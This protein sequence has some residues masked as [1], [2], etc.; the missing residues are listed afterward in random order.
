MRFYFHII[1][2]LLFSSCTKEK[3]PFES[4]KFD[5]QI[6]SVDSTKRI[7]SIDHLVLHPSG[8][9]NV[10]SPSDS[11]D[12]DSLDLDGNGLIDSYI[13]AKTWYNFISAS[14]P[15]ANYNHSIVISGTNTDIQFSKI[16]PYNQVKLFEETALV[17]LS[18]TWDYSVVLS[19]SVQ[20]APFSC[21]FDGTHYLGYRMKNI[22]GYSY[23]WIKVRSESFGVRLIDAALNRTIDM[24]IPAGRKIN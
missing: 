5:I 7:C 3:T 11:L 18:S 15:C 2:A 20:Q 12:V 14:Y 4:E 13:Y 9:G 17:D 16:Q 1:L 19:L 22:Q 8:C 10:P 23:G 21:Y 24:G 6:I